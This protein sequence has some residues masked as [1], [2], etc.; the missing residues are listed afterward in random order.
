M[1]LQ[2]IL[3]VV[4]CIFVSAVVADDLPLFGTMSLNYVENVPIEYNFTSYAGETIYVGVPNSYCRLQLSYSDETIVVDQWT[5]FYYDTEGGDYTLTLTPS[6]SANSQ[7]VTIIS[8]VFLQ[9]SLQTEPEPADGVRFAIFLTDNT[10]TT[11]VTV[12]D[13]LTYTY[14]L[15]SA[16]MPATITCDSTSTHYVDTTNFTITF[17]N[18]GFYLFTAFTTA[19]VAT[20]PS[21][22][23]YTHE[24]E[25]VMIQGMD[26]NQNSM[27]LYSKTYK[28]YSLDASTMST[29][30]Q[31]I[32]LLFTNPDIP[33]DMV[34]GDNYPVL[35]EP[36]SKSTDNSHNPAE[37]YMANGMFFLED[38][39]VEEHPTLHFTFFAA[40]DNTFY[41]PAPIDSDGLLQT[42]NVSVLSNWYS[43]VVST[44][45][46]ARKISLGST[47]TSLRG[48]FS[49]RDMDKAYNIAGDHPTYGIVIRTEV[50]PGG[51]TALDNTTTVTLGYAQEDDWNNIT[52]ADISSITATDMVNYVPATSL[53]T[54]ATTIESET[55]ITPYVVDDDEFYY[56]V[57]TINNASADVYV[58]TTAAPVFT[59]TSGQS[60]FFTAASNRRTWYFMYYPEAIDSDSV[61]FHVARQRVGPTAV[62]FDANV[63]AS[64]DEKLP[65]SIDGRY[66]WSGAVNETA[67]EVCFYPGAGGWGLSPIYISVKVQDLATY[68][69]YVEDANM[70]TL[71]DGQST[72]GFMTADSLSLTYVFVPDE[73]GPFE[74]TAGFIS[75]MLDTDSIGTTVPTGSFTI[76]VNSAA[77]FGSS[78]SLNSTKINKYTDYQTTMDFSVDVYGSPVYVKV[79]CANS[80]ND[81]SAFTAQLAAWNFDI[82]V[83]TY[84][85]A[86]DG[87]ELEVSLTT[88]EYPEYVKWDIHS[89]MD[90][91]LDIAASTT[92]GSSKVILCQTFPPM[93]IGDASRADCDSVQLGGSSSAFSKTE[94]TFPNLVSSPAYTSGSHYIGIFPITAGSGDIYTVTLKTNTHFEQDQTLSVYLPY[95]EQKFLQSSLISPP[96]NSQ[97]LLEIDADLTDAETIA[98]CVSDGSDP[99]P[100]FQGTQCPTDTMGYIDNTNNA[101]IIDIGDTVSTAITIYIT[102]ELFTSSG[103]IGA[104][105]GGAHASIA[106]HVITTLD[107]DTKQT[108]T[109]S[110][111]SQK[112]YQWTTP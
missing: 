106:W 68:F 19:G 92:A 1:K 38:F 102:V 56:S 15:Y 77:D 11:Q 29:N 81:C 32:T 59:L 83:G 99:H 58:K 112:F 71:N 46:L 94:Y 55:Y 79:E 35:P 31:P 96:L 93:G 91:Y 108:F 75:V 63:Y 86:L 65:T 37:I 57:A 4:L 103:S 45:A 80:G 13:G 88:S 36:L 24:I 78:T 89:Q 34:V 39:W 62:T 5:P 8:A 22:I 101:V 9:D 67:N 23:N 25:K 7:E 84:E 98:V 41:W 85:E 44:T 48:V 52:Y 2:V 76:S 107:T 26:A 50:S 110:A 60:T 16:T 47:D 97:I 10:Q 90:M 104:N 53:V 17:S 43:E 66:T 40:S 49:S 12:S 70:T 6:V 27:Y 28:Y 109:M 111:N 51:T 30:A 61:C 14:M 21:S 74:K 3:L 72:S 82:L 18:A 33:V 20:Y 54:G 73:S 100:V 42:F 64:Q 95:D 105:V 69:V 87:V